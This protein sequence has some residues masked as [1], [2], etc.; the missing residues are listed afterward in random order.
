MAQR[1]S[2][3][4]L[5]ELMITLAI[6]GILAGVSI[7]SMQAFIEHQRT[8]SAISTLNSHI[9][10][11]RISAVT[12][13]QR[14][15]LCPTTNGQTCAGGTDWSLGWMV[16]ADKNNNRKLD[17]E[18]EVLQTD[19]A[20]SNRHLRIVS[21][22]GRQQLRYLPDGRSA[23]SNLTLSV[24]NAKGEVLGRVIVNN[25]GRPR[26]ERPKQPTACPA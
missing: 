11:A 1:A 25:V 10:L 23:G 8:S 7:P 20:P 9:A 17:A 12:H 22:I 15:V 13:N 26:S 24:C 5:V 18:D 3:F 14:T 16:F 21:S 4:T 2:G 6:T 19:L